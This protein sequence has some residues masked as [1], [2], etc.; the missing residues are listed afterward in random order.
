LL[1]V[2]TGALSKPALQRSFE[3]TMAKQAGAD[4]HREKTAKNSTVD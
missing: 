2:P 4:Q 1:G 3:Q